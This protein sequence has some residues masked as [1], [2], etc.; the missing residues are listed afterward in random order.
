MSRASVVAKRYAKALFEVAYQQNK[1]AEV[2][3]HLKL[4]IDTIKANPLLRKFLG[5]PNVSPEKKAELLGQVFGSD[6]LSE[7]THTIE[8]LVLRGRHNEIE[9]VAEAYTKIAG[10]ALGQ[11]NAT[12]YTAKALSEA[13]EANVAASFGALIGKKIR[14]EQ[15]V[16]PELLG[17]V[18]VR[19]GDRLYDGSLAGKLAR[20]EKSLKS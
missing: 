18:Q 2:E 6:G 1:V 16:N 11:A 13:E 7:V 14:I 19:I 8:L 12:V 4:V 15:V 17:G 3:Q 9:G 5:S 10:E 20:L